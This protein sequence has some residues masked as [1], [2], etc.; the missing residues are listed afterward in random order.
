MLIKKFEEQVKK[1]PHQAAVKT[2]DMVLTYSELNRQ[3]NRVARLLENPDWQ[4][5]CQST[6]REVV[7]LFITGAATMIAAIM[8]TLKAGKAYV[9][10]SPDFPRQR[11]S[12]IVSHSEAGVILT[13]AENEAAA[14][15]L[16]VQVPILVVDR[17][18]TGTPAPSRVPGGEPRDEELLYILYTS[19]STGRPK[20]VMQ[21]HGN[22]L[23]F[24]TCY[25]EILPITGND[26]MTL[27]ASFSHDASIMDIYG[28]LCHGA[29][30]YPL[31]IKT[32]IPWGSLA[33][34]L[35]NEGI[36]IWHS[37]PTVYRYFVD[38]LKEDE[39]FPRLR[40]I[41]LGGEAVQRHDIDMFR[42]RF[43]HTVLYNLY[44]QTESSYNSGEFISPGTQVD[45]ITLGSAIPGTGIFVVDE[46]GQVVDPLQT[47][48]IMIASPHVSPGYW[49]DARASE[50]SFARDDQYGRLYW[51]GDLGRLLVDGRIVF[52]GRKDHQVKI[53]GFRVELQEIESQLLYHNDIREAAVKA[54]EENNEH[55]LSAYIVS[56]NPVEEKELRKFL[57]LELPDYMIPRYFTRLEKLPVTPTGKVDRKALP[58]PGAAQTGKEYAP[59]QDKTGEILVEIWS[60]VLGIKKET[61]SID[62]DFFSLGGH[63]LRA[64]LMAARIQKELHVAF[65]LARLFDVSTIR[66]ISSII[67]ELARE[68]YV[69]IEPAEKR[70]YN[71][72]SSA[73]KRLY[74]LQQMEPG[75]TSYNMSYVLPLEKNIDT[76]RLKETFKKLVSR[77]DNLRTSFEIV[78]EDPV[79]RAHD[80]VELEI[81]FY[82][83]KEESH[84][85]SRFIRPF[86]LSRAPLMRVGAAVVGKGGTFKRFLLLDMHHIITDGTSQNILAQ[87]FQR[88]Y[89][90]GPLPCLKLHYKD[91]SQWQNRWM[92]S[93]AAAQ[94]EIYWLNEFAGE[95]PV[96]DLPID[97]PRAE[98]QGFTGDL[99]RFQIDRD[100]TLALKK[101][102]REKGTTLYMNLL[103]I[104]T[105]FLA[106]IC[107][108]EDIVVGTPTAGRRLAELEQVIGMF[109]NILALKNNP[110]ETKSFNELLGEVREKTLNAFKNQDYPFDE[111]VGKLGVRA[112]GRSMGRNPVVETH[113][114]FQHASEGSGN[115][116]GLNRGDSRLDL[117]LI[118][119]EMENSILCNFQYSTLLFKP[120]TV[121]KFSRY[122]KN[123]VKNVV[124]NPG[125]LIGQIELLSE[126][127]KEK[128]TSEVHK[129]KEII[130][131]LKGV[132]FNEIF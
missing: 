97:Y 119:R 105:V 125:Q 31:D 36:T 126:K 113:F 17:A 102:A 95:I 57:S 3:A 45:N 5:W 85:S 132:D 26:R 39:Q 43:T 98:F 54:F 50:E 4:Q 82:D 69:S 27:L 117:S 6:G 103:T 29:T 14:A 116:N 63:S 121:K 40:Y 56:E 47:G 92:E 84:L 34:W 61:I 107:N 10:L 51:T 52:A 83:M 20:G 1:T 18:T 79:Q 32:G 128:L 81:E 28:A 86:D 24:I 111:L 25:G 23:H 90:E 30:L 65:P 15:E 7:G 100:E 37:V 66:G 73:Q 62:D 72:L 16:G 55:Y 74:L 60:Q 48:E 91:Y 64:T 68:K 88:L 120:N 41:V 8:G 78:D 123:I 49:K 94:Q 21:N 122:L 38:S 124:E 19:G 115:V 109:V 104:Y 110:A 42:Q 114:V 101:I 13:D 33:Q 44:G 2:G 127:E 11:L 46:E 58:I 96:L 131:E 89:N 35:T 22:V 106:K 53:R 12:Y 70:E 9:P 75:N 130:K 59:P 76:D 87:E 93:Q 71:A 80:H 99:L 77:H 112:G 67:K 118:A 129:N 108:Q